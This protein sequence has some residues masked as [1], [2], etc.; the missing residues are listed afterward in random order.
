MTVLGVL[1]CVVLVALLAARDAFPDR[2]PLWV[3]Q[4]ALWLMFVLLV[5]PRAI[6]LAT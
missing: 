2:R 3:V 4:V 1:V 6:A 5:V